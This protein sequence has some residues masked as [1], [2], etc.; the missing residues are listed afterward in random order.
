MGSV[1]D[2]ESKDVE[3]RRLLPERPPASRH[4]ALVFE[5]RYQRVLLVAEDA[6]QLGIEVW[7]LEA[8]G[9]SRIASNLLPAASEEAPRLGP[10]VAWIEPT[11][12]EAV[13]GRI[14]EDGLRT[15]RLASPSEVSFHP[16]AFGGGWVP[17]AH[18]VFHPKLGVPVLLVC[19]S[20]DA[21][22]FAV[23]PDALVLLG[24]ARYLHAFA[25]VE[26]EGVP[27]GYDVS[28][29]LFVFDGARFSRVGA[30][31]GLEGLAWHPGLEAIVSL[32]P[33][34]DGTMLLAA[35]TGRGGFEDSQPAIRASKHR[36]GGR[37]VVTD[38]LRI[39]HF[40]GQDFDKGGAPT[41]ASLISEPGG[42]VLRSDDA[43]L[44]RIGRYTSAITTPARLVLADHSSVT[45]ATWKPGSP[46]ELEEIAWVPKVAHEAGPALDDRCINFAAS[47]DRVLLLDRAG[48]LWSAGRGAAFSRVAPAIPGPGGHYAHAVAMAWDEPSRALVVF[49]GV[50]S[51]S[52]WLWE[53]GAECFVELRPPAPP[54]HGVA[55]IVS[56]PRGVYLLSAGELYRFS[57]RAWHCVATDLPG[58][59][60][61]IDPGRER[62]LVGGFD[63]EARK[64]ALFVVEE[65]GTAKCVAHLPSGARSGSARRV[66][67]GGGVARRVFLGAV[68]VRG[69]PPPPD[70]DARGSVHAS[71]SLRIR[72]RSSP[73]STPITFPCA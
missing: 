24:E 6:G 33:A 71:L 12:G 26:S 2:H 5:R 27:M 16:H 73:P 3:L 32:R 47:D 42:A 57:D 19:G 36:N 66:H 23:R 68:G 8:P 59:R 21:K 38:D 46:T 70:S 48:T 50:E 15:I 53:D 72:R 30:A 7:A 29:T 10:P 54:P 51:N 40:G 49:G 41:N 61:F 56:T 44:P 11:S 37:L 62:L 60:L 31:R 55:S 45:I 9:F 17:E 39:V 25:L 18:G 69:R 52:T 4:V 13:I 43:A 22:I 58:H 35:W 14:A 28:G 63:Q 65:G 67:S 20:N 34:R 1:S 64:D